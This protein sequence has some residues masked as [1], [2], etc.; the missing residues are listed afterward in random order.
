MTEGGLDLLSQPKM[1]LRSLQSSRQSNRD[2]V[3]L[4]S[5]LEQNTLLLRPLIK[6]LHPNHTH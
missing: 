2:C 1:M 4:E 3:I 6:I 5:G